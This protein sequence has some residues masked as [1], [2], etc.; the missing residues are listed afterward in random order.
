MKKARASA[1]AKPLAMPSED[2]PKMDLGMVEPKYAADV[3]QDYVV[4]SYQYDMEQEIEAFHAIFEKWKVG[5]VDHA[6]YMP[7]FVTEEEESALLSNV[8]HFHFWL[9]QPM[10]TH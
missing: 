9:A 5:T 1:K 2:E 10:N 8:R 3:G 6:Y 4:E 7:N